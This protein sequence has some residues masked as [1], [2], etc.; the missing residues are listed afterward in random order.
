M[1]F[2]G[3]ACAPA[4]LHLCHCPVWSLLYSDFC[5]FLFSFPDHLSAIMDVA[6][7]GWNCGPFAER[8]PALELLGYPC[9]C[10][11]S[12][13]PGCSHQ[14]ERHPSFIFYFFLEQTCKSLSNF[15]SQNQVFLCFLFFINKIYLYLLCFL[16]SFSRFLA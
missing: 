12:A 13:A 6:I 4:K 16:C 5:Q 7:P 2:L 3:V 15:A 9:F 8:G 1:A 14:L 10:H 11:S